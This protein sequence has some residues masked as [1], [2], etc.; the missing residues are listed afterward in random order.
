MENGQ[1]RGWTFIFLEPSSDARRGAKQVKKGNRVQ[2]KCCFHSTLFR[3]DL[4]SWW[5]CRT[6]R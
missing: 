4:V 2:D 6:G 3:V 5:W 1:V